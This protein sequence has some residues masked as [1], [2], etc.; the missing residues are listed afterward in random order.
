MIW[1]DVELDLSPQ[2]LFFFAMEQIIWA[3]NL[4]CEAFL[5]EFLP[6][7]ISVAGSMVTAL[8]E[9]AIGKVFPSVPEHVS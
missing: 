8:Q 9:K 3:N 5:M 7:S 1:K 2:P 4:L 6:V